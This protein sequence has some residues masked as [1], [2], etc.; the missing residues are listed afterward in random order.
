MYASPLSIPSIYPL[1]IQDGIIITDIYLVEREVGLQTVSWTFDI[2]IP[3]RLK[4]VHDE[5]EATNRRGSHGNTPVL[6]AKPMNGIESF[7]RF[8]GIR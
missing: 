8:A 6:L 2:G 5:V 3:P 7:V 4:V 1:S